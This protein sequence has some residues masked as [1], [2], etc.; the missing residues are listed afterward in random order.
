MNSETPLS[1]RSFVAGTAAAAAGSML[2]L[3]GFAARSA[4]RAHTDTLRIGL[5]GCGGRGTG[6]AQQALHADPNTMLTAVGDAFADK[7]EW[8]LSHLKNNEAIAERIRVEPETRFS[9]L[10]AFQH[11]IDSGVDVVLLATPPVFRPMHLAAAVSAGKHVFCEKPV[12][13][14][15]PG[16]RSVLES[17]RLAKQQSLALVSGFCWRYFKPMREAVAQL[18]DGAVG[19]ILAV[20]STYNTGPLGDVAREPG[21]TD[22]EWQLR[23]WKA[24]IWASGDHIVEQAVHAID[25]MPW[26]LQQEMPIKAVSVGGRIARSGEWTGN[27]YDHFGVFFEYTNGRR[28]YHMCRQIA[29]CSHDNT[30]HVIGS[31][32]CATLN[33]WVPALEITGEKPWRFRGEKNDMYQAEHDALFASIR[34]GEPINDGENMAH[35]TM[36]AILARECAYSGQT[37]SWD[38]ALASEKSIT[39]QD[40][41]WDAVRP[42]P[43][44]PIPGA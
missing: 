6:A 30:A 18:H 37:I 9:G 23:N 27:M 40:W 8:S 26:V 11:V 41:T 34:K 4:H 1:R 42:F 35:S 17:A 20:Q 43:P 29:G 22:M 36:M 24:F 5:I 12:A 44:V 10:D 19:D 31:R 3:P 25:W 14:D 21:M 2:V 38:D 7:I 13:V 32:G 28:A 15:A 33:P 16:V 39:P